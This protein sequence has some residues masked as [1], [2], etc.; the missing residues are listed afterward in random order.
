[1]LGQRRRRWTNIEPT[2]AEYLC[3]FCAALL[4][5][6]GCGPVQGEYR[7]GISDTDP[8]STRRCPSF[9]D[10]HPLKTI[11][12][13]TRRWQSQAVFFYTI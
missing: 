8:T 11:P 6:A 5:S 13:N 4:C 3:V 2:L 7:S 9:T 1:M 12:A 10:R